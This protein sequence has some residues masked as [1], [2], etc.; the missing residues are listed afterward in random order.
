MLSPE[1]A[2]RA[3]DVEV[4][5]VLARCAGEAH[6]QLRKTA[7][8]FVEIAHGE[9]EQLVELVF[10]VGEFDLAAPAIAQLLLDGGEETGL[11]VIVI[12]PVRC[13]V[14]RAFEAGALTGA[15]AGR[16][17]GAQRRVD[18]GALIAEAHGQQRVFGQVELGDAVDQLRL[19]VIAVDPGFFGFV[20]GD[21]SPAD[22]ARFGQRPGYVETGAIAIPVAGLTGHAGLGFGGGAFADQVD[23]RARVAHA[24]DQT[25]GTTHDFDTIVHRH[26]LRIVIEAGVGGN[27]IDLIVLNRKAA[28]PVGVSLRPQAIAHDRDAGRGFHGIGE[29]GQ[30][31]VVQTLASHDRQRLRGFP[32]GEVQACR[33]TGRV[34]GVESGAFGG[35]TR[36]LAGNR[37]CTQLQGIARTG[38]Q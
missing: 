34:G 32:R 8:I 13:G 31:L 1:Q 6:R 17:A 29:V 20:V 2:E 24:A 5:V 33:A 35:R 22:I 9:V 3:G 12:R 21:E 4:E 16:Q 28:R 14:D 18:V 23:G 19:Q 26:A 11:L 37:H 25:G 38:L 27:A 36:C 30:A 7:A 10:G 15:E